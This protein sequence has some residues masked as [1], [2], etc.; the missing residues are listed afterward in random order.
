MDTYFFYILICII[1]SFIKILQDPNC[2]ETLI[3]MIVL[4]QHLG[5][6][7]EVSIIFSVSYNIF[8]VF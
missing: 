4:S 5:K 3:N 2:A 7:T 1:R 6:S 8:M